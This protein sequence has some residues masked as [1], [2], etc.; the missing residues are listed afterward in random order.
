M[1]FY[2]QFGRQIYPFHLFIEGILL[3]ADYQSI[4]LYWNM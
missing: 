4:N 3:Q 2:T 1:I